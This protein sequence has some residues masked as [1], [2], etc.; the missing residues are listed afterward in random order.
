ML[1]HVP[2]HIA[3]GAVPLTLPIVSFP[4][5]RGGRILVDALDFLLDVLGA[6]LETDEHGGS[7]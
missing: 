2:R 3:P 1:D 7:A 6:S 5:S 4:A